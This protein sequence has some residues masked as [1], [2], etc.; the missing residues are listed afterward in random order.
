MRAVTGATLTLQSS[1]NQS[2]AKLRWSEFAAL[3]RDCNFLAV[4]AT[5]QQHKRKFD[6]R[7]NHKDGYYHI[8]GGKKDWFPKDTW[9]LL[10]EPVEVVAAQFLANAQITFQ[11]KLR[12]DIANAVRNCIKKCD[13]VS[14]AH[15][16][17]L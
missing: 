7:C 1:G 5:S 9:L 12:P 17:L 10:A 11:D 13:D 2:S 14:E 16:A 3:K 4:I 6:P 8:P 15:I